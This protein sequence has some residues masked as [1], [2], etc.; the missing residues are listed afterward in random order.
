MYICHSKLWYF[1]LH[2]CHGLTFVWIL[3]LRKEKLSLWF[4]IQHLSISSLENI[5]IKDLGFIFVYTTWVKKQHFY[6]SN[7][8]FLY[9]FDFFL[10]LFFIFL[11]LISVLFYNK[12][13]GQRKLKLFFSTKDIP[14][15]YSI[16]IIIV[17]SLTIVSNDDQLLRHS[18][19]Y[20][21]STGNMMAAG[22][23]YF[24]KKF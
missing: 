9:A 1:I 22:E 14:L 15:Y 6:S 3:H 17:L 21:Q 5:F 18:H 4:S 2:K 12:Q 13:N 24:P 8:L 7:K 20:V 11:L 19:K 10:I 23:F 16:T